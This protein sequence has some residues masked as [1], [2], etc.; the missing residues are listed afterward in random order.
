MENFLRWVGKFSPSG[1]G[2]IGM[3]QV[4]GT[5]LNP[6]MAALPIAW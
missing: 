5:I 4:G 3:L 1:N 2:L 6:S